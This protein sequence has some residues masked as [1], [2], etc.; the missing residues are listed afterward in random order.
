LESSGLPST[1][2]A[3]MDRVVL[4][5]N[6]LEPHSFS[7]YKMKITFFLSYCC[8]CMCGLGIFVQKTFLWTVK[9]YPN[10]VVSEKIRKG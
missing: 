3:L 4:S 9:Y 1:W 10:A 6:I 8:L 7:T 5:F 2:V